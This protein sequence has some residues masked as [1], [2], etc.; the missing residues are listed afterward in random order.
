M[1]NIASLQIRPVVALVPVELLISD[2]YFDIV[3]GIAVKVIN[4]G[5][6]IIYYFV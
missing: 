6:N 2:F 3:K 1:F 4:G 5:Y